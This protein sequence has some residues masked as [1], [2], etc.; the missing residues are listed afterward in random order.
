MLREMLMTDRMVDAGSM[1]DSDVFSIKM[2]V[3]RLLKFRAPGEFQV[4][5]NVPDIS[6]PFKSFGH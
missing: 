1:Y 6:N 2:C 3:S 4:G 5:K